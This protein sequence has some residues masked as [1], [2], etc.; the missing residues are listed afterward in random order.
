MRR[1]WQAFALLMVWLACGSAV[2]QQHCPEPAQRNPGRK[3][4]KIEVHVYMM[5]ESDEARAQAR[6][7]TRKLATRVVHEEEQVIVALATD[8]QVRRLQA[9]EV[10][11]EYADHFDVLP[12]RPGP[13][14]PGWQLLAKPDEP[15]AWLVVTVGKAHD[16][17][18]FFWRAQELGA[19]LLQSVEPN[20]M[21]MWMT[22]A[23]ARRVR[24]VPGVE[25]VVRVEAM[26]KLEPSI[27]SIYKGPMALP[28]RP[29][30]S[31]AAQARRFDREAG[32]ARIEATIVLWN[33]VSADVLTQ[34][35]EAAV[36]QR[37]RELGGEL[38][39]GLQIVRI[40]VRAA[41]ELARMRAVFRVEPHFPVS[42][43]RQSPSME[44]APAVERR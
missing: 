29:A 2:A 41:R 31:L 7:L 33:H 24:R 21:W 4:H 26:E 3:L 20:G 1:Q 27:E 22:E 39:H 10:Y 11:V 25:G 36:E 18:P 23:Q 42:P 19:Q 38:V 12:R 8:A 43:A 15:T 6:A 17:S 9:R 14:P 16:E 32:D 44:R 28:C 40:P 13:V 35:D 34:A 5:A 37:V 30:E